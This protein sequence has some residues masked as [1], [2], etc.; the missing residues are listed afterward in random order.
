MTRVRQRARTRQ[1]SRRMKKEIRVAPPAPVHTHYD[2]RGLHFTTGI[3]M[4]LVKSH[5]CVKNNIER[6]QFVI[7]VKRD[8]LNSLLRGLNCINSAELLRHCNEF[9][10][11]FLA[12]Q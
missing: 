2:A 6:C 1:S 12:A 11:L 3:I 10:S 9:A 7:A 5:S 8:E 4:K